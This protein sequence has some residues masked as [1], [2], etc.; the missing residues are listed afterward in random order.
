MLTGFLCSGRKCASGGH[1]PCQA[2]GRSALCSHCGLECGLMG[3][4]CLPWYGTGAINA[5]LCRATGRCSALCVFLQPG[6]P[7]LQQD[8]ILCIHLSCPKSSLG[9][10]WYRLGAASDT[11]LPQETRFNAIYQNTK[12]NFTELEQ[13]ILIYVETQKTPNNNSNLEKEEQCWGYYVP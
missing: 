9:S 13:I 12:G 5:G 11:N 8:N 3:F 6:S 1:S 10:F 7:Q 2:A 4:P